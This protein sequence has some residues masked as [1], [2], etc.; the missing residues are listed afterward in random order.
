MV[1]YLIKLNDRQTKSQKLKAMQKRKQ[2]RDVAGNSIRIHKKPG[3]YQLPDFKGIQSRYDC[4]SYL[5]D[6]SIQHFL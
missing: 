6:L 1:Y 5:T 2:A 3:S 4:S